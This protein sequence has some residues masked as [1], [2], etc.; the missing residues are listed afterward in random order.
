MGAN[1]ITWVKH[2]CLGDSLFWN[3]L[4]LFFKNEKL[5]T[6]KFD[7]KG[8]CNILLYTYVLLEKPPLKYVMFE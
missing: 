4:K 5:K 3:V 7:P 6:M 2:T 8:C 1:M